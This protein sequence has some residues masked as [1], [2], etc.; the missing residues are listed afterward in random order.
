MASAA[1]VLQDH[2]ILSKIDIRLYKLE[3]LLALV[4]GFTV[5]GLI[6]LAVV[7]VGG[8]NLLNQPLPGYIDLIEQFM[9]L[10]A[11]MGIAFTQRDGGHIRMDML[12]NHLKGRALWAVEWLTTLAILILVGLLIWGTFAH[13]DRS[14]DF[15]APLW[16][17]DSTIDIGLPIWPAKL[18]A[19]VAFSILALRLTIQLWAYGRAFINNATQPV[20]V[21]LIE[22]VATQAQREADQL[23]GMESKSDD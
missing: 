23:E 3:T 12:V 2:S 14:F 21:P 18:L 1:S 19:P 11:F 15:D 10:I 6:F 17:R 4:S 7:S 9:P 5:V 13:F 20:A 22:D 16:S 8:R